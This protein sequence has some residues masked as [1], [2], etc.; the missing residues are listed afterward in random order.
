MSSDRWRVLR[1]SAWSTVLVTPD[2]SSTTL[3]NAYAGMRRT[4]GLARASILT[5]S[6]PSSA[7]ARA[8][9]LP[10]T[11]APKLV[12]T[13]CSG[14]AI[15][16]GARPSEN[17]SPSC[18]PRRGA[19]KPGRRRSVDV[20]RASRRPHRPG[21]IV[22]DGHEVACGELGV[23]YE[24]RRRVDGRARQAVRLAALHQVTASRRRA[25][26]RS[27]VRGRRRSHAAPSRRAAR[28]GQLFGV[29]E[30]GEERLPVR[31]LVR[32]DVDHAV[33]A[34]CPSAGSRSRWRDRR[35]AF[36]SGG[37]ARSGSPLRRARRAPR[38][39]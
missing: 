12:R 17:D 33:A 36:P 1:D 26:S 22:G 14:R 18:W 31:G 38:G 16:A 6:A 19:G 3:P 23:G 21:R 35:P 25:A 37:T 8:A 9:V 13:P 34:T 24:L 4:S 2:G 7:S 29:A 28:R 5:T 27:P 15:V 32:G 30:G 11:N 20:H 39:R 10:A